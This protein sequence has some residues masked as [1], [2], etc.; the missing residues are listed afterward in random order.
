[1]VVNLFSAQPVIYT[2][3]KKFTKKHWAYFS[4]FGI[5]CLAYFF[6]L[7]GKLF[8]DPYSTVIGDR[9]GYLMNASIATDGQWRFPIDRQGS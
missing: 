1:M 9:N 3:L 5:V 7:P 2:L 8:N 4:H 6:S